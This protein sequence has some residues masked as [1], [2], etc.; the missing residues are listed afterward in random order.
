MTST[1]ARR[2]VSPTSATT[3]AW[4]WWMAPLILESVAIGT[5]VLALAAADAAG[6]PAAG[7]AAAI[8]TTVLSLSAVVMLAEV[9][10]SRAARPPAASVGRPPRA[11][12]I[13]AAYLPNE[14]HHLLA[15]LEHL[16]GVPYGGHLEVICAYN[17]PTPLAVEGDLRRLAERHPRLHVLPVKDSTS[18]AANVN[19]ALAVATGEIVGIFDADHHPQPGG[20]ERAGRWLAAGY[21]VVQGSCRVRDGGRSRL[22]RV[23]AAEF[24]GMY[25]VTH[26]GRA[27]VQGFAIFGGSNGYWRAEVLRDVLLDP[28][29]LTEDIDA[30]IRGFARGVRLVTDPAIVST[31]LAPATVA[32]LWGQRVRWAQGWSQ[33]A[34]HRLRPALLSPAVSR[35][36]RAGL[37]WQ[38]GWCEMLPWIAILGLGVLIRDVMSAGLHWTPTAA[39]LAA[40]NLAVGPLHAVAGRA[41]AP[42]SGRHATS[43]HLLYAAVS[44]LFYVELLNLAKRTGHV[45][46][47]RG[48][49]AWVVTARP[50]PR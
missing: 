48:N 49:R 43:W 7:L 46:E 13:V 34:R 14:R 4:R 35:R 8:V 11:T 10:A 31:E 29:M 45:R 47:I 50:E 32:A 2:V 21:D 36:A 3:H 1:L 24:D 44:A 23:V 15:T 28:S 6:L 5:V 16:L 37:V 18:K 39:A 40:F 27:R 17:T 42:R 22:A 33:V 20:F 9:V 30:S 12:A 41:R 25:C 19:A 38:F 26:P